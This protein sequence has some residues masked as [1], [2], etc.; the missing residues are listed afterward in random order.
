MRNLSYGLRL[1]A[2]LL[3]T[4]TS[5]SA[6][7]AA[8]PIFDSLYMFSG[9]SDGSTPTA[10]LTIGNGVLYGTTSFGGAKSFGEVFSLTPPSGGAGPWTEAVLH[11][12][13]ASEGISPIASLVMDANGVLYGTTF[14]AGPSKSGTVFSLT[15]PASPGGTWTLATLHAFSGVMGTTN[16]DGG[17]PQSPVVIG[18][19]G[20]LYGTTTYGGRY[21]NG[22]AFSLTPPSAPGGTWTETVLHNFGGPNDGSEPIAGLLLAADGTLYG[23]TYTGT[24]SSGTVFSLT[25]PVGSGH[26]TEN[27]LY[28]FTGGNDGGAPYYGSLVMDSAGVLYGTTST[29]GTYL[30]GT[31]FSLTP[32]AAAGSAWTE[33]VLFNFEFPS[34]KLPLGGL[35]LDSNGNLFGTTSTSGSTHNA[36]G[37]VFRLAPPAPPGGNWQYSVLYSFKYNAADAEAPYAGV[38]IGPHRILFGTT[39]G[40]SPYGTGNGGSV[41]ALE[42]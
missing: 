14:L 35:A 33:A 22:I 1:A 25:P 8:S 40:F 29:G 5:G 21:G 36:A 9:G 27:V 11:S 31:V 42:P 6:L 41:F 32:P 37:T 26:W 34:G 38:V 10:P 4:L 15:P 24:T 18:S 13:A 12:F 20:V 17:N 16:T 7:R 39:S 19:G 2:A 30:K 3:A 28:S 23:T